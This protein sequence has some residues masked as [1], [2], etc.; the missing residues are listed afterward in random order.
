[1][2]A[3]IQCLELVQ[4]CKCSRQVDG[5][6]SFDG[7]TVRSSRHS[8]LSK[9]SDSLNFSIKGSVS[10]VKRP[11]QSFLGSSAAVIICEVSYVWIHSFKDVVSSLRD[12]NTVYCMGLHAERHANLMER[13]FVR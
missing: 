13:A 2:S 9:G 5:R 11:P 1:M 3:A 10:P 7:R 6:R 12:P 4:Q 8:L